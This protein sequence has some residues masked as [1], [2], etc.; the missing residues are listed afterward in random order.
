MH[1]APTPTRGSKLFAAWI[2]ARPG[3]WRELTAATGIDRPSMWRLSRG[4][5]TP[6]IAFALRLRELAGI[7]VEAWVEPA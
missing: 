1:P 7:P 4:T 5:R 2:E 3:T 6:T